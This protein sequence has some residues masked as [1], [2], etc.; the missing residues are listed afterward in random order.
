MPVMAGLRAA[1]KRY[2]V[3]LTFLTTLIGGIWVLMTYIDAKFEQWKKQAS[4]ERQFQFDV[5]KEFQ[6]P[7]YQRQMDLCIEASD[8]AATLATTSDKQ[9]ASAA[10]DTFWRLY[11]GPL[12][13]VEEKDDSS[14]TGVVGR[15]VD[16]GQLLRDLCPNLPCPAAKQRCGGACAQEEGS[17]SC[18]QCASL[19]LARACRQLIGEAWQL[20]P[21]SK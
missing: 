1:A 3:L 11:W 16:Y 13:T 15:M 4:E 7:F 14:P 5:R 6:K 8:A 17:P 18:L 19:N 20:A 10:W 9:K 21:G 2:G 12:V